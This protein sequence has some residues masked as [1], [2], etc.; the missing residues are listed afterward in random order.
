MSRRALWVT[1]MVVLPACERFVEL[2]PRSASPDASVFED[3]GPGL[4]D[5]GQR[6]D[7]GQPPDASLADDAGTLDA[8][9]FANLPPTL[10]GGCDATA[11]SW[12]QVIAALDERLVQTAAWRASVRAEVLGRA[13]AVSWAPGHDSATLVSLDL[14]HVAPLLFTSESSQSLGSAVEVGGARAI[15]FGANPFDAQVNVVT[16]APVGL[17]ELSLDALSWLTRRDVTTQPMRVVLAHLP[18]VQ[19]FH[20]ESATRGWLTQHVPLAQLNLSRCESQVLDGC[21]TNADLLIIGMAEPADNAAQP[22]FDGAAALDAVARARARGV[23]VLYVHHARAPTAFG[24]A[25]LGQLRLAG[26]SNFSAK[27]AVALDGGAAL[28]TFDPELDAMSLAVDGIARSGVA[29][30]DYA[31][32]VGGGALLT[33]CAQPTWAQGFGGSLARL[34]TVFSLTDTLGRVTCPADHAILPLLV[35]A[36]D[37][38]RAALHY[39]VSLSDPQAFARAAF[40]DS[41]APVLRPSAP[42]QT[43]LGSHSCTMAARA[44]GRCVGAGYDV[45]AVPRVAQQSVHVTVGVRTDWSATGAYALPG[46]PITVTRAATEQ[47]DVAASVFI[48]FQ[49]PASAHVFTAYSRPQWLQST[50]VPLAPG[51][52][53]TLVSPWGGPLYV[54]TTAPVVTSRPPFALEVQNAAQHAT[55]LDSSSATALGALPAQVSSN[56]IP[57][58]DLRL[59]GLEVHTRRDQLGLLQR[60]YA[61]DAGAF[62]RA[63]EGPY[64]AESYRLVGL[65]GPGLRQ[66]PSP[67][68]EAACSNLGWNCLDPV[69]HGRQVT[70]HLN[71]DGTAS[72]SNGCSGNPSDFDW[73]LDPLDWGQ[74]VL[75]G[76]DLNRAQLSVGWFGDAG[77]VAWNDYSRRASA[78]A[79]VAVHVLWSG[80]RVRDARTDVVPLG[81]LD[82]AELFALLQSEAANVTRLVQGQPRHVLFDTSCRVVVDVPLGA[83]AVGPALWSPS[84]AGSTLD[85]LRVL[86]ML[87]LALQGE[88]ATLADGTTLQNGFDLITLLFMQSRLFAS[89][90]GSD[91]SWTAARSSLGFGLFPWSGGATYGTGTVAS[92]PANDFLV[93]AL[94]YLTGKDYRAW[95]T[96]WGLPFSALADAQ[97]AAHVSSGRV[98]GSVALSIAAFGDDLYPA[99]LSSVP[100]VAIDGV[101]RWPATLWHPNDCP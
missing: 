27:E 77:V 91:A 30:S 29:V 100:R 75:L 26:V 52:S 21:L 38:V 37:Q 81:R 25:L 65:Q 10:L 68:V 96:L 32:C 99:P 33:S 85:P 7:A 89:A 58:V 23:P 4:D 60:A 39:P 84:T 59:K 97:V 71:Y 1:V 50:H 80:L 13:P 53:R 35:L 67:Q 2:Y 64:L 8:G 40:A 14:D 86:F 79:T 6:D 34:R 51:E 44:T 31:T 12:A 93:V 82:H 11:A 63:L 78:S 83:P 94:S 73:E 20:H 87:D 9:A 57:H 18:E 19:Y 41:V 90:A 16:P 46:V 15:A 54:E 36:A 17:E 66:R 55:V 47:P 72:C 74:A 43:D 62:V 70:Q 28:N 88:G 45:A 42:A 76:F 69:V 95:F 48:G 61:N 56:P 101:A 24:A 92:L 5:A 22:P 3:S 49:K 98:T